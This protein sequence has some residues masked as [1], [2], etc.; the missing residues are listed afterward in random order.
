MFSGLLIRSPYIDW[1]LSGAKTWEIR[2]SSTTKRD[3]IAL[4]QSGT[5]TVVGVADL[6]GVEGPLT[7][8]QLAINARKLGSKKAPSLR[9]LPYRRTF[10]WVLKN[11]RKLKTPVRYRH[12]SGCIIWV[13]L[14]P[15][16]QAAISRQLKP[17]SK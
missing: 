14:G 7:R 12:P 16:V 10:A 5:G 15:G 8:R 9:P 17:R 11:A 2:G 6:V 1:I 13:N 3:L 4:I